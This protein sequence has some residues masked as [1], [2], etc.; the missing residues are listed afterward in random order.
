MTE[1]ALDV[2]MATGS[3]NCASNRQVKETDFMLWLCYEYFIDMNKMML[4][5]TY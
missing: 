5:F 2:S 3:G 4:H 1:A